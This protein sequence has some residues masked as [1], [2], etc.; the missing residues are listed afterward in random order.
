MGAAGK[1]SP[2]TLTLPFEEV[3]EGKAQGA[4][5]VVYIPPGFF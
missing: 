5:G 2:V 4:F 3:I 1:K